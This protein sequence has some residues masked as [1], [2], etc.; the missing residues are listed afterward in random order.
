VN[1]AVKLD[2]LLESQKIRLQIERGITEA[3]SEVD[4]PTIVESELRTALQAILTDNDA[5]MELLAAGTFRG[6]LR[7]LEAVIERLEHEL[8]APAGRREDQ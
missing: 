3:L 4:W 6:L 1:I 7:A 5:L 2:G 8:Q